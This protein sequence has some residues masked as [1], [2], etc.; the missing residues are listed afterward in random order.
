M[1]FLWK[2]VLCRL[3][4]GRYGQACDTWE[5]GSQPHSKTYGQMKAVRSL[6]RAGVFRARRCGEGSEVWIDITEVNGS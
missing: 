4:V 5:S 3:L 6:G 1:P 2:L